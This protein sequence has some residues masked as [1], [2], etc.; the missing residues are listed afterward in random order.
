[1]VPLN[2]STQSNTTSISLHRQYLRAPASNIPVFPACCS[3]DFSAGH[4]S[5]SLRAAWICVCKE[6]HSDVFK[7]WIS[8]YI[9]LIPCDTCSSGC[10][11]TINH[12]TDGQL[13][14][15]PPLCCVVLRKVPGHPAAVWV[16]CDHNAPHWVRDRQTTRPGW[17]LPGC[18]PDRTFTRGFPAGFVLDRS[19]SFP[20]PT[21]LV[22]I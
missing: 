6:G 2:G 7:R 1:M 20:D 5:Y 18:Y 19:F 22:A 4:C 9:W 12:T 11:C 17:Q 15:P 10:H 8:R 3:T 14:P 13:I 21:S 16:G